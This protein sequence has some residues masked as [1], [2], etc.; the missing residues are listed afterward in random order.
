MS[1]I[2]EKAPVWKIALAFGAVYLIWGSTYLIIRFAIDTMPPLLMAGMRFGVA[3]I[4]LYLIMHW[5]GE[6]LPSPRQL[7]NTAITGSLLLLCGNGGVTWAE[8]FIPSGIAALLNAMI[9][10]WMLLFG[11]AG[12]TGRKPEVK[13]TIAL[14]FGVAGIIILVQ[15]A[16]L[17]SGIGTMSMVA[18]GVVLFGSMCWAVGS[19]FARRA[20]MPTSPFMATAM[21][22]IFGGIFLTI[23]GLLKGEGTVNIEAIS[24]QSGLALVYLTI[25]G[26]VVAFSAYVWLLRTVHPSRAASYAYVN[27]LIAVLLGW[28][29]GSEEL[30]PSVLLA[31]GLIIG[32]VILVSVPTT[33]IRR[34]IVKISR[35]FHGGRS[36]VL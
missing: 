1:G 3:G 14:L 21:Q 26:S 30:T 24:L 20:D 18:M 33:T 31:A 17:L 2:E 16:S 9:P 12:R 35:I 34:L 4:I 10:C 13:D 19:L 32:A 23:A 36:E 22:M 5:R 15:P 25:F 7:R 28:L 29:F 6:R 27:P 8:Q 11:M